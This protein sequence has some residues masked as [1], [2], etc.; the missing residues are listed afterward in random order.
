MLKPSKLAL[1]IM[2]GTT[3]SFS[4]ASDID[5]MQTQLKQLQQQMQQL[6]QK[7]NAAERKPTTSYE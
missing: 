3:S 1:A 2:L 4:F 6:Q 7:L 5:D